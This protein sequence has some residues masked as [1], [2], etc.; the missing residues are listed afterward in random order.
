MADE[1]TARLTD[2]EWEYAE[3]PDI[4]VN[5]GD[6]ITMQ[7]MQHNGR[8]V[9][10]LIERTHTDPADAVEQPEDQKGSALGPESAVRAGG[11]LDPEATP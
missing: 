8:L 10:H 6:Q 5:P 9:W 3:W 4:W 11:P 7:V 2:V 1:L